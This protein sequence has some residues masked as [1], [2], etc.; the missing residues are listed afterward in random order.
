MKKKINNSYNYI[1]NLHTIY[2]EFSPPVLYEFSFPPK[3]QSYEFYVQK[4]SYNPPP[5][6]KLLTSHFEI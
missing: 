1:F 2:I 4:T 6:K 3:K 5:I